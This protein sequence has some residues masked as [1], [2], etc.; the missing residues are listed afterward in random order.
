MSLKITLIEYDAGIYAGDAAEPDIQYR[1]YFTTDLG[2]E[3]AS[4]KSDLIEK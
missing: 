3:A 4:A 2:G 1:D